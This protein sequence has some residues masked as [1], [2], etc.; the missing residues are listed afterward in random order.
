MRKSTKRSIVF[1]LCTC[2]GYSPTLP[3]PVVSPS[4]RIIN[5]ATA[6]SDGGWTVMNEDGYNDRKFTQNARKM[7]KIA[8]ITQQRLAISYHSLA[9]ESS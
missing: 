4:A 8:T 9:L 1:L 5:E 3:F 7:I 6:D 2:S